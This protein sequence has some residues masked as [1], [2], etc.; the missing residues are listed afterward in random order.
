MD[1]LQH[2]KIILGVCGG[3]AAYK[4]VELVRRLTEQG[5]VVRVVMTQAA[6]DFIGP[7][8]FHAVS[9]Q[10][11][12][13]HES[14][15]GSTQA[16]AHIDLARWADA[17][18]IAPATAHTLAKLSHG[19]ADDLLSNLCL[20]ATVPIAVAPAMNQAM[21]SHAAT[22]ANIALLVQRGVLV[23]GPDEGIQACGEEGLGRMLAPAVLLAH[24]EALL[25][26]RRLA[27]IKL[28][29]NAGPTYEDIDAV[30]FL[31]NRSSGKMGFALAAAAHAAGAKVTLISGPVA[32]AT[33]AGVI[34][35]DVRS[36]EQMHTA[37][38]QFLPEQDIFIAAAAVA[39]FK[40]R[41]PASQK[42]KKSQGIPVIELDVAAD[43]LAAVSTLA[44]RPFVVGFAA[45]T[46]NLADYAQLKLA[47]KR[48]DMVIA[49]QITAH[50]PA[51][52]ADN[53]EVTVF[54]PGG[55]QFFAQESKHSLAHKLMNTIAARFYE[56]N[57]SQ[58]S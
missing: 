39:D 19:L 48:L 3:I 10:P 2:K 57:S 5:A 27:G 35:H 36:C 18:L 24:L 47:Q 52:G 44:K 11:C 22:Q 29:I 15:Q 20:A 55:Q 56:K 1:I 42:I 38:M 50:N 33:P 32:L 58:N 23:W 30:R 34:R 8:T 9:G 54:W 45:E 12:F 6:M 25:S 43:I 31:G 51:M 28:L 4:S 26:P 41:Q 46:T 7:L 37:V 14:A 21:W 40:I 53:N 17:I 49:N 16:M 13:V